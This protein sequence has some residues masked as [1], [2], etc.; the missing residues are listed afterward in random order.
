MQE[1]MMLLQCA[2]LQNGITPRQ[3][4]QMTTQI[5]EARHL[6]PV[7]RFVLSLECFQAFQSGRTSCALIDDGQQDV[8][9]CDKVTVGFTSQ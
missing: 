6:E 2:F 3:A 9:P 4:T 7:Y 5:S 1:T 8:Q